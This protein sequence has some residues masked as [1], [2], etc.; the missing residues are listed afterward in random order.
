MVLASL[1]GEVFKGKN[2]LVI[3]PDTK[4]D[5]LQADEL[6]DLYCLVAGLRIKCAV[7]KR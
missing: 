3:H 2:G 4:V 1:K 7:R 5:T 6:L